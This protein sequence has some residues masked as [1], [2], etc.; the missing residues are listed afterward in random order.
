MPKWFGPA[1]LVSA[2]LA[3]LSGLDVFRRQNRKG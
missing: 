3:V 2:V 1:L